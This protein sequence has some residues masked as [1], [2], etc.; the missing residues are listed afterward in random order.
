MFSSLVSFL[1]SALH[2]ND[3]LAPQTQPLKAP[4]NYHSDDEEDKQE[5]QHEQPEREPDP[6]PA[7]AVDELGVKRKDKE[8]RRNPI[9]TFIFVRPPPSKTNHPLNLQ[10]QLIPPNSRAP[11]G[12]APASRHSIDSSYTVTGATP[13][14]NNPFPDNG[15]TINNL[16]SSPTSQSIALE[17][18]PSITSTTSGYGSTSSFSSVASTASSTSTSSGRRAIIPLYNLQAHNVMT[19]VIV[20]AGTDAKVAKFQ[21]KGIEVIDLA[22]L[23]PIEV[24]GDPATGSPLTAGGTG[25]GGDTPGTATA[26]SSV[27]SQRRLQGQSN[28]YACSSRPVTPDTNHQLSTTSSALSLNSNPPAVIQR[29]SSP[30]HTPTTAR[31]CP[32]PPSTATPSVPPS[33]LVVPQSPPPV[34]SASS[35]SASPSNG[36]RNIFGRLFKKNNN[37]K[38]NSGS[39]P[40]TP[41]LTSSISMGSI[42]NGNANG[43]GNVAAGGDY[44]SSVNRGN[45]NPGVPAANGHSRTP[46]VPVV[47][48]P[49]PPTPSNKTPTL[50]SHPQA[51]PTIS[52]KVSTPTLNTKTSTSGLAGHARNLSSQLQNLSPAALGNA[53]KRRSFTPLPK[54][55]SREG[56][57]LGFSFGAGGNGGRDSGFNAG[58]GNGAV[59]A[60]AGAGVGLYTTTSA[61]STA[62]S[63]TAGTSG[64]VTT[65]T[66]TVIPSSSNMPQI[67]VNTPMPPT[68][69]S[70]ISTP[71]Q[72]PAS[73]QS[74]MRPPVL[75]L[76]AM[77]SAPLP[78][79]VPKNARALMYVWVVK[80]WIKKPARPG[81]NRLTL[82]VPPWPSA[83]VVRLALSFQRTVSRIGSNVLPS[84]FSFPGNGSHEDGLSI[85]SG[86][87]SNASHGKEPS[88][89]LSGIM[90]SATGSNA[91][92]MNI[93]TANGQIEVRFEW[94]RG[95][96]GRRKT[97]A[98]ARGDG[99]AKSRNGLGLGLVGPDGTS[100]GVVDENGSVD[101]KKRLSVI[102][103]RS[104]ESGAAEM[105]APAP[106]SAVAGNRRS[107]L[108][109]QNGAG[110]ASQES[111]SAS[112]KG[113]EKE[114]GKK[115]KK[116]ESLKYTA[117]PRGSTGD[118]EGGDEGEGSPKSTNS[119]VKDKT[120]EK[121]R[122][123]RERERQQEQDDGE[124][125]DPEDSET[126]WICTL[127][128][129]RIGGWQP[130]SSSLGVVAGG[131]AE[132]SASGSTSTLDHQHQQLQSQSQRGRQQQQAP[133][134]VPPQGNSPSKSP[135]S[136]SRQLQ[137]QSQ[138]QGQSQSQQ[139]QQPAVIKI[140]VGTLSPTPHHPKVVAMLKVPYPLPDIEIDKLNV[141]SRKK[142]GD[143]QSA[144]GVEGRR[145]GKKESPTS[146][147]TS[148]LSVFLFFG[149][150]DTPSRSMFVEKGLNLVGWWNVDGWTGPTLAPSYC[151]A[152]RPRPVD[153][154]HNSSTPGY[155]GITL[156]A[157][158][159]KDIVC[160]TGLW[161]A[162]RE[163][164][165][166][167]GK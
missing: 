14:P 102:S 16:T 19:N 24:W 163:G 17:R 3:N 155:A 136:K 148:P 147:S 65:P 29:P 84:P 79:P 133:R 116:R 87:S 164:F 131:D 93:T 33:S 135:Y 5:Q 13:T 47:I 142:D 10:V 153:P 27:I 162:V 95:G 76:Q 26:R 6:E 4:I 11:T 28:G 55:G 167:I 40:N 152:R 127:K 156:T 81:K 9:E 54:V 107:S 77:L 166:G 15:T 53:V 130:V 58:S 113:K 36:K 103:Q 160:S 82:L 43:N 34:Q 51:H 21:K 145:E 154:H 59:D 157:E 118:D 132:S 62:T 123:D 42:R 1:P 117:S 75:G 48:P 138:V 46:S 70:T 121:E 57:G 109:F 114:K 129:R 140:K 115:L 161:L 101:S 25:V 112:L 8:P 97:L 41:T 22:T 96:A 31:P 105:S 165:G 158:E 12:L 151:K 23:E 111:V 7:P 110:V 141:V 86:I 159:I 60:G 61:S 126:P 104:G 49:T 30:V 78:N 89:F 63:N 37:T 44:S 66:V 120:K 91:G 150:F 125:S 149:H 52:S 45:G 106:A 128:V 122:R 88:G 137:P 85:I 83:P 92:G 64:S 72:A 71:A 139:Q 143:G 99:S 18:T 50:A 134:A 73:I 94:R 146:T 100:L 67:T 56:I 2:I 35:P 74:L 124:E 32:P 80:K 108:L 38:D 69:S 144:K 119:S 20:D 68:M 39:V 90:K 98:N